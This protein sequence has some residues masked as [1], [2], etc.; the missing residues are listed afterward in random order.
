MKKKYKKAP[1]KSGSTYMY[2]VLYTDIL[3]IEN[4]KKIHLMHINIRK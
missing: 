1:R 3:L 4:R 2:D